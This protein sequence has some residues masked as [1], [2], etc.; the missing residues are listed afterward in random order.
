MKNNLKVILVCLLVQFVL[1][2]DKDDE[3]IT[4]VI[5]SANITGVPEEGKQLVGFYTATGFSQE[6]YTNQK[7]TTTWWIADDEK[8]TNAEIIPNV[9]TST[10]TPTSTMIGKY[11]AVEILVDE[12]INSPKTSNYKG[13]IKSLTLEK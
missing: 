13:P 1:S 12:F 8:G 6:D 7:F 3:S 9:T 5:T 11:L 2:C 4:P 10:Y